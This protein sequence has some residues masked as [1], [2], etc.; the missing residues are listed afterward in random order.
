MFGRL[1][2]LTV[3]NCRTGFCGTSVLPAKLVTKD[4]VD[5]IPDALPFPETKIVVDR[6]PF[7]EIVWEHAP[8]TPRFQDV[9]NG[10]QNFAQINCARPAA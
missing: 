4:V 9:E 5:L 7:R 1:N 8:G 10:I 3:G 2:R 6:L